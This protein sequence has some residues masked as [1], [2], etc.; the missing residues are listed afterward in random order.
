MSIE[1]P[2]PNQSVIARRLD[3]VRD[4]QA[5]LAGS[6]AVIC[7]TRTGDAPT[8]P[9]PSR[10]IAACRSRVVLPTTTEAVS[11]VLK[12]AKAN[13]IK[14]V[15]RGAGTS[16]WGGSLPSED[17]IVTGVFK[18]NKVLAID[19]ENRF[20]RVQSGITNL[21]ISN[22]V[23]GDGFFYAPDP[24]RPGRLHGRRQSRA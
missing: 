2:S 21:A 18:M 22:A 10:P 14:V 24:S 16:L 6:D 8:R 13:G 15:A 5:A 19:L 20:V 11:K 9:M 12:Y 1:L 23:S 17:A 4:L 3:I 7:A